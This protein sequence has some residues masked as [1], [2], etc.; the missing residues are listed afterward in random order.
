MTPLFLRLGIKD[1]ISNAWSRVNQMNWPGGWYNG[2]LDDY[3]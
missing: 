3:H 1:E 2:R